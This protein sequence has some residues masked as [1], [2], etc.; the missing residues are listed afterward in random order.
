MARARHIGLTT[1]GILIGVWMA[2]S[3]AA[4]GLDRFEKTLK[5]QIPPGTLTYK[6]AKGLGDSGFVLQDVTV[7][8]PPDASKPGDKNQPI[9]V[10]SITVEDL[11]FD[12]IEKQAPPLFAKIRIEGVTM[13]STPAAGVDLKQLAGIDGLSA[14]LL[15][16]YKLEPDR[17]TFSLS[18]MEL[19]LNSLGRLE[20]SLVLD[21]VTMNDV[22]NPS[23]AMDAASLRTAS[24]V[25][26]DHSLLAKIIPVAAVMQGSD[27]DAMLGLATTALDGAREGQGPDATKAIDSLVAYVEDYKKPKGPLRITLNPPSKVSNA[28]LNAAKSADDIVKLLGLSVSYPGSRTSKPGEAAAAGATPPATGPGTTKKADEEKDKDDDDKDMEK[29]KK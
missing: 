10:K 2:G 14:D 16:D 24:L 15:L 1:A 4:N 20:L 26:D 28:D 29:T 25:Y 12:S 7:V 8:T 6:S 22:A 5:P 19:N 13:G 27:P 11:D 23:G 17:K 9:K 18:R 21:G 3:A